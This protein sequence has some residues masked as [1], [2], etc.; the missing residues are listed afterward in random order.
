MKRSMFLVLILAALFSGYVMAE[1]AAAPQA[2]AAQEVIIADFEG[3]PN[4]LGGEIG[5]YGSLEPNWDDIATVPYSWVYEPVTPGYNPANVHSGKQ[6]FRLVNGL[7]LKPEITWGSFAMDLGPTTDL[8]VMPKKVES[9]NASGFKYITFWVKGEKGGEKMEFVGRDT[10]ALNYM[11]QAKY[12]L[13]DATTEWQKITIPLSEISGKVD[14]TALDNIGLAF[15]KDVGNVKGEVIYLDD[16]A[17][18][19]T[20]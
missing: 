4:N 9:F 5:V 18:T 15:G 2:P 7:G 17:F 20:Q 13:P 11:P 10:H 6:S 8:T 1:E 19:N 16:F 12:K 14:A 3:W